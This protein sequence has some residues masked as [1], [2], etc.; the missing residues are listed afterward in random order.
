MCRSGFLLVQCSSDT[1]DPFLETKICK[2]FFNIL[3]YNV[4]KQVWVKT[5]QFLSFSEVPL[6]NLPWD[7]HTLGANAQ[8]SRSITNKYGAGK[9][10]KLSLE[11]VLQYKTKFSEEKHIFL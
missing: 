9:V 8:S 7:L 11:N 5:C 1:T 3:D 2:L 10:K 4:P 6:A